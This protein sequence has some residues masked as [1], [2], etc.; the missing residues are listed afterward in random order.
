MAFVATVNHYKY[1]AFQWRSEASLTKK[2]VLAVGMACVTGIMAQLR[3]YL[4]WSP[5]PITGQT[6]AVLLS[7]VLLGAW[8][9]G[10]S[11][12]IYAGLGFAGVPWF[13]NW[14]GGI[15]ML[16]GPTC[17]YI[18]G[19]VFAS[20]FIGYVSDRYVRARSF[21]GMLGLM[22]TATFL[23]IHGPGL[24]HL[25]IWFAAFK[26]Q[27]I[28]IGQIFWMGS[29]PFIAGDV[30]KAVVAAAVAACVAPKTAYNVPETAGHRK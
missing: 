17:G 2:L 22:L 14:S 5:V 30:T 4:P 15:A 27:P 9:G 25:G 13:A 18:V 7:G 23:L 1:Q 20:F 6:F 29:I 8:G 26:G 16:A 10:L 11:Q 24:L 21:A 28:D 3:I 19:F 12:A